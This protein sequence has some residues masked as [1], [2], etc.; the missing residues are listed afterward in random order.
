MKESVCWF[1]FPSL[2]GGGFN[3]LFT[4]SLLERFKK[5]SFTARK[6]ISQDKPYS[7]FVMNSCS[8]R[9]FGSCGPAVGASSQMGQPR[10]GIPSVPQTPTPG[11]LSLLAK[12]S[13]QCL[14]SVFPPHSA[15]GGGVGVRRHGA[16]PVCPPLLDVQTAQLFPCATF[17][18]LNC[19]PLLLCSRT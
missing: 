11:E 10:A 17:W 2:L 12:R 13:P 14:R 3:S 15:R 16:F 19:R 5:L 4:R 18:E 7:S 9:G 6:S 1:N 8:S